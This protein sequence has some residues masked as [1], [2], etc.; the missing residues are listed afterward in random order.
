MKTDK[1][2]YMV[3][4]AT[5]EKDERYYTY[6]VKIVSGRDPEEAILN[7]KDLYVTQDC[8]DSYFVVALEDAPRYE[9]QKSHRLVSRASAGHAKNK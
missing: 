3:A 9:R 7:Y 6:N 8:K 2:Y 5:P 1:K 4:N